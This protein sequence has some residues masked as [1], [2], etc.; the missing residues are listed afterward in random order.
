[1]SITLWYH[2]IR[3]KLE[4]TLVKYENVHSAKTKITMNAPKYKPLMQDS[5]MKH[6]IKVCISGSK[7]FL[8][9]NNIHESA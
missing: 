7:N 3:K 9:E 2:D 8:L 6:I 5:N 4:N 1:M